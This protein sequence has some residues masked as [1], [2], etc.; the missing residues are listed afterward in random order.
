MTLLFNGRPFNPKNFKDALMAQVIQQM[1]AQVRAR[2]GSIR[3][4]DTGEFP[5]IVVH[6]NKIDDLKLTIEGSDTLIARVKEVL[7]DHI[8]SDEESGA[9]DQ[10]EP[11]MPTSPRVFLSWGSPDE[12]LATRL[13]EALQSKGIETWFSEWEICPGDSFRQRIDAGLGN[14]TH[15]LVLLTPD[16]ISRP[17]VNMEIDAGLI[18]KIEDGRKFIP[19]RAGVEPNAL[20]PL[21]RTLHAPA[22]EDFDRDVRQIVNDI[23]GVTRKP[24]LGAPPPAV[25]QS[26]VGRYS[27]AATATAR[28]FVEYSQH[29]GLYDPEI[30]L[31]DL[32]QAT[33]LTID[34]AKDAVFELGDLLRSSGGFTG[35]APTIAATPEMFS[36]FDQY[37]RPWKPQEDALRI[38]AELLNDANF[39]SALS[40]IA[41]RLDWPAR[42][43]NPAVAYLKRRSLVRTY[44]TLGCVPYITHQIGATDHTRRFVKS[45]SH[46]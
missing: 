12:A 35:R 36:E 21:L 29:G 14:A 22:L 44:D 23:Y 24:P 42:R 13:A 31:D 46:G 11:A 4:P 43:L 16:S 10:E 1:A 17:W 2:I 39:P 15:F 25:Q 18:Q 19:L 8:T 33:S 34:D 45:R 30:S 40:K 7:A 5:T 20:P 26:R 27:D 9:A 41:E 32:A 6:G 3:D 37:W 38:A 28:Y